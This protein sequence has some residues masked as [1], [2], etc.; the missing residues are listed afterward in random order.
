MTSLPRARAFDWG[1]L[2]LRIVSGF[3]LAAGAVWAVLAFDWQGV[4]WRAPFVLLVA[5]AGILLSLEW[6]GMAAPGRALR[7]GWATA[8]V[9][10]IV[11][12][13]SVFGL[14]WQAWACVAAG[15]AIS[16]LSA[17]KSGARIV[18]AA[19]GVLYI[20]PAGIAL[21]WLRQSPQGAGWT[22][23][24]FATAWAADIC[25]F[26]VGNLVKGPKLW[27]RFSPNKTWSG[28]VGGLAAAAAA[29]VGVAAALMQ[30]VTGRRGADRIGGR[31]G[32][33]GG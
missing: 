31:V 1:N 13:L 27:P 22:L 32:H 28:F 5:V 24:L 30:S 20:A 23:M 18:D 10:S 29:S 14:Y 12:A 2:G 9:V 16:A 6:A 7:V 26:M 25:A 8:A 3:I 17:A 15:A 4:A 21:V 19:Y 33:H 11:V